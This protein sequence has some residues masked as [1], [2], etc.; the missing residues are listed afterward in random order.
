MWHTVDMVSM[1]PSIPGQ[2]R[3]ATL[4]R[5]ALYDFGRERR[6]V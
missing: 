6:R 4:M 3:G 2:H 5:R 1:R